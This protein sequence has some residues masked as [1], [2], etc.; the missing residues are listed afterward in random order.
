MFELI[1]LVMGIIAL[2][3]TIKKSFGGETPKEVEEQ[4][5]QLRS[6]PEWTEQHKKLKS[7]RRDIYKR[8]SE[9]HFKIRK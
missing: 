4:L 2:A 3:F 8:L 7:F 9:K 5:K 6:T 1:L